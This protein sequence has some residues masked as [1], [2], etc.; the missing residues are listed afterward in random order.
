MSTLELS[1]EE[2]Q[3]IEILRQWDGDDA[4]QLKIERR[5]SAWDIGMRELGTNR[6]ARGTGATFD[7]AWD[8]MDPLWA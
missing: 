1:E 2:T 7:A 4:Y 6:G 8:N 5:D 3:L